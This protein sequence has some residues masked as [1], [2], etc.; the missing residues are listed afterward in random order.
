MHD[1]LTYVTVF[2]IGLATG[3]ADATIIVGGAIS[4]PLLI[5]IGLPTPVAIATDRLGIIGQSVGAM[6][7]FL[8]SK[9]IVWSYVPLFSILAIIG[10]LIGANILVS[11][12]PKM[13]KKIV[14]IIMLAVLPLLFIKKKIGIERSSTSIAKKIAGSILYF[15]IMIYNGIFG[16]GG[17][18]LS[19]YTATMLFGFTIIEYTAT[20]TIPW[21]ILSVVSLVV[22]TQHNIVDYQKGIFFILGMTLGGYIGAHTVLKIGEVWIKRIVSVVV[23]LFAVKL[24]FF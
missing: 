6:F 13:L 19:L 18:V 22:F 4:I 24:L 17:G 21:F 1:V 12:D 16:V 9:K 5:L 2:L 14:G 20:A 11:I 23:V 3:F 10:G 7:G 8:R 15:L